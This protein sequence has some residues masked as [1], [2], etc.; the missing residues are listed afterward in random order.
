MS[1]M[2][3]S[4]EYAGAMN[5]VMVLL[6]S[7][8]YTSQGGGK[9]TM[10]SN[11]LAVLRGRGSGRGNAALLHKSDQAC[12]SPVILYQQAFCRGWAAS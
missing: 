6:S 10:T 7:R 5:E 12:L 9:S 4:E 8:P 3:I 2:N 1:M 11:M